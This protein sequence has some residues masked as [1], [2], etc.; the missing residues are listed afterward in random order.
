MVKAFACSAVLALVAAGCAGSHAQTTTPVRPPSPPSQAVRPLPA[1]R[2]RITGGSPAQQAELRDILRAVAPTGLETLAIEPATHPWTSRARHAVVLRIEPR[3]TDRES[4]WEGQVVGQ[5]FAIASSRAGLPQVIALQSE[6]GGTRMSFTQ[7][8]RPRQSPAAIARAVEAAARRYDARVTVLS[9]DEVDGRP[10][11]RLRLHVDDPARFLAQ[12]YGLVYATLPQG[13]GGHFI[14]VTDAAGKLASLSAG[15]GNWGMGGNSERLQ[16]CGP[17]A[18]SYPVG[19]QP[20]PCPFAGPHVYAVPG[21]RPARSVASIAGIAS[22]AAR[23]GEHVSDL[24]VASSPAEL[25]RGLRT[26][27]CPR[28][29]ATAWLAGLT[30][31][32]RLVGW[33]IVDDASGH[34]VARGAYS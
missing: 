5:A 8:A 20:P 16:S 28:T 3:I 15:V 34:V 6:L 1:D 9:I 23:D 7:R 17:S 26:T 14:E 19:Y 2:T 22:A 13:D 21:A 24:T 11:V 18:I 33:L 25:C 32:R 30:K 12:R 4:E 31:N 29:A 27:H 10:V